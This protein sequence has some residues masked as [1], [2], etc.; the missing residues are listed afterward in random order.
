[1]PKLKMW[2]TQL[3]GELA[4]C[5]VLFGVGMLGRVGVDDGWGHRRGLP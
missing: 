3:A 4:A 5:F 1:M 2:R